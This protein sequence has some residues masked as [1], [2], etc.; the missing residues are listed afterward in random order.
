M[1]KFASL[2]RLTL[3]FS[4]LTITLLSGSLSSRSQTAIAAGGDIVPPAWHCGLMSN[5]L[6]CDDLTTDTSGHAASP[7]LADMNGD[8]VLDIVVATA[9]GRIIA[10]TDN[11]PSE[12]GTKLFDVDIAPAYGQAANSQKID[13]S[14]AVADI[15]NDGLPE[16]IVGTGQAHA[17][18]CQ[19]G[20][21]IVLDHNGSVKPGWP[22]LTF[23]A[24]PS[25]ANCPAPIFSSPAVGD[26]D[27]DGDLEIVVGGFDKRIYAWHHDGT[28][29]AGFPPDSKHAVRFDWDVLKKRLADTI[30]G[31]PALADMNGDGAPDIILGTDEGN[32]DESWGGDHEGWDCPY[33]S[34]PMAP[35]VPGYCG[36]TL[37]GLDGTG[38]ALPGFQIQTLEILQSTPALY[39][40]NSDGIPEIFIGT[41]SWYH[42]NSPD[43]PTTGFRVFGWDHEGNALPG[44]EGGKV[45]GDTTPASPAVGDI[46]GDGDPEI[47]ALAM[48]KKLYAWHHTGTAVSGFP[49]TPIDQSGTA[50][51]YNVGRGLVLADY[52]GD[53]AMEAFITTGWSITIVDGSGTQLTTDTFPPNAPFYNAKGI[54]RNMPAIG[55][56]DG[57]GEAE[58]VVHNSNLYVWD[59]PGSGSAD[60]PMFKQNAARTSYAAQPLLLSMP[61][62]MAFL[63]DIDTP[64]PIQ[65]S[66]LIQNPGPDS[67]N[68]TATS[69]QPGWAAVAPASGSVST[70]TDIVTLTISPAGLALG[71]HQATVTINGGAV[72]G[73]PRT[74]DI[75]V[76]V[77]PEIYPSHLPFINN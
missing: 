3:L 74:V 29:V 56:V 57:D 30:W 40:I 8:G 47:M 65:R 44:W 2:S 6:A 20:G 23:D 26:L 49:M 48:D 10:I 46:D 38:Q 16:V 67:I 73:S 50:Y 11:S 5:N 41:G 66:I 55:D 4:I 75:T 34:P 24:S 53:G 35:W 7:V 39:D 61:Q 1:S 54:L 32:F 62:T 64:T 12:Y 43:H 13:S 70:K 21:V 22:Q 25:P 17:T 58:M 51:S 9:N 63:S 71:T 36:G 68:W 37:Y 28:L 52:T 76:I 15:D 33:A 60:W 18:N 69:S 31:S 77:V 27:N 42:D 19:K 14:P 45:V 72:A 59:L